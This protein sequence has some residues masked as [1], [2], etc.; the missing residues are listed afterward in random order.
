MKC[1]LGCCCLPVLLL[2]LP[3]PAAIPRRPPLADARHTW[4]FSPAVEC[5]Q[6]YPPEHG[7]QPFALPHA[8]SHPPV[9]ALPSTPAA[10]QDYPEH[11]LQF[12]SL[13]RAI[14]NHCS[15]TLF[16]MSPV[17]GAWYLQ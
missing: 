13:L 15:T 17:S 10:V 3:F 2:F 5:L 8:T 1:L 7:V 9:V 16:A 12:F 6:D 4:S 14:T 11:R